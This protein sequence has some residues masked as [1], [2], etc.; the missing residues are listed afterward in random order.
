MYDILLSVI[1]QEMKTSLHLAAEA[2]SVECV[3]ELMQH[4]NIAEAATM[5]DRVS[6]N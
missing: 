4:A 6:N 5:V 2:G 3:R 1:F